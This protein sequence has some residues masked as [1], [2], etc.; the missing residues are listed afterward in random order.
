MTTRSRLP[1]GVVPLEGAAPRARTGVPADHLPPA[2]QRTVTAAVATATVLLQL[3]RPELASLVADGTPDDTTDVAELPTGWRGVIILEGVTTE[4]HRRLQEN[5]LGWRDLPLPFMMLTRTTYGHQEAEFAG[6]ITE[7]SREAPNING[8]GTFDL[9]GVYG[10]EAARLV[11]NG[12]I[13]T[14]S[15]DL[16]VEGWDFVDE[17][18]DPWDLTCTDWYELFTD[19]T[20]AGCHAGADARVR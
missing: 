20:L 14:V 15:A 2:S 3:V 1:R 16:I 9:E 7:V 13:T 5:S 19:C 12:L 8:V 4:D 10:R 11:K 18:E 6:N 17:C